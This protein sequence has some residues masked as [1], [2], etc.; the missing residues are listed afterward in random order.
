MQDLL[1]AT[2]QRKQMNQTKDSEASNSSLRQRSS[3]TLLEIH[4]AAVSQLRWHLRMLYELHP[5]LTRLTRNNILSCQ[6][7]PVPGRRAQP[8]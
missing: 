3:Y 8:A 5:Q 4:A 2:M 1:A 7:L 6:L